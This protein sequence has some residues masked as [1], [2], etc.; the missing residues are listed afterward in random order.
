MEAGFCQ[1]VRADEN[2]N[3]DVWL[4]QIQKTTKISTNSI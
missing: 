3:K 1:V 4:F 2:E